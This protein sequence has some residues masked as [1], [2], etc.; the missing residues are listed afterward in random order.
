M[1]RQESPL[2]SS[3][4]VTVSGKRESE[5]PGWSSDVSSQVESDL[6]NSLFNDIVKSFAVKADL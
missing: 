4:S 1:S 6:I 2:P 3:S 5:R